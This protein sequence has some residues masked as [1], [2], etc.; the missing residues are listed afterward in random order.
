M[1]KWFKRG[2]AGAALLAIGAGVAI[3]HSGGRGGYDHGDRDGRGYHRMH[4]DH[5]RGGRRHHGR[6]ARTLAL[7]DIVDAN[8]DG[9]VDAA[10]FENARQQ[11]FATMDADSDGFVSAEELAAFRMRMRAAA[12][13]QRLD[14]D[15]DGL[16]SIDEAPIP[17][18]RFARVER[19]DLDEN[20]VVTKTELELAM[21]RGRHGRG[22][23][24]GLEDETL[25]DAAEDEPLATD[26]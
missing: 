15:G 25:D 18:R 14:E 19:F 5:E 1:N 9:G 6:Q 3:A 20:G 11:I 26:E 8:G 2:V 17:E 23:R 4:D 22:G 16:L 12:A 10:E 13:I 7:F 24:R 21:E